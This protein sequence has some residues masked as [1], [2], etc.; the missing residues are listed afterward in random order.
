MSNNNLK[1]L[2]LG[3]TKPTFDEKDFIAL[4]IYYASFEYKQKY[5]FLNLLNKVCI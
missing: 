4:D 2:L 1:W 5:K 3:V